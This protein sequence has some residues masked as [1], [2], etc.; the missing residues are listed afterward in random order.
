MRLEKMNLKF[1]FGFNKKTKC[2]YHSFTLHFNGIL[3]SKCLYK[4]LPEKEKRQDLIVLL[5]IINGRI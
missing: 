2:K 5:M 4:Q 3:I 1:A